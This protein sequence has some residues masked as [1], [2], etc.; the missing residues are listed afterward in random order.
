ML[1]Q[2][3]QKNNATIHFTKI[4]NGSVEEMHLCDSCAKKNNDLDFDFDFPFSFQKI[5]TGLI[6]SIQEGK[7]EVKNIVCSECGL[8]YKKFMEIGRFGCAN[9]YET[10]REDV[11][12]LL[13]GIHGHNE[14]IGKVPTKASD[15]AIQKKAMESLKI[16]LEESIVK[17]DFE[18]AA[19]LRDEIKKLKSKT[20]GYEG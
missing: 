7:E 18:R 5:F 16:Q 6:G 3:C 11:D 17:E 4:V 8:T 2:T 20:D 10:F 12:S 15:R 14:H 13:K 9:C 1:C 19:F